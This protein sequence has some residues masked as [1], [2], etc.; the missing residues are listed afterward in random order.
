[1]SPASVSRWPS[2]VL[3]TP[4]LCAPAVPP[5]RRTETLRPVSTNGSIVDFG[6]NLVG[7]LRVRRRPRGDARDPAPRRDPRQRRPAVHRAVA[8]GAR[9]PTRSRG[10]DY[11]PRFTFHGF[12]YAEITGVDLDEVDVEAVVVHTDLERIGTFECSDPLLN[13]LH[14]NVVWGWRGNS[15]SVPT[16]CPQRDERLGWTGD[17]QVFS[18]TASFLYDAETFWE[19]W[20]ARRRRR[21]AR[22][23]RGGERRARH[24][25]RHPRRVRVGRRRRR[26]AVDDVRRLRRRH[27]AARRAA[28]DARVGRL[29]V[30]APRRRPSLDAGL[31]V[32]RLARPGR[33]D[34]TAVARQGEVRPRRHRLRRARRR[35]VGARRDRGRRRRAGRVVTRTVRH[36]ARRVVEALRRRRC[37]RH[38][39][40]RRSRSPSTSCPTTKRASRWARR[41]R[42]ACTTPAT[43]SPPGSSARRCCCPRSRRP[44][45][46]TSPTTCCCN[47]ARPS[48][49][50]T[51]LA[52]ATTI[53]ERWD[54]LRED[55]SV[56]LGSLDIGSGSSM[57][58]YNHYA[59]G[60][61]PMD[62]RGDR[63]PASRPRRPRLPPLLRR[64]APRWRAH[65]RV[66]VTADAL[67]PRVRR[68][69][70]RRRRTPRRRRSPTQHLGHR[71]PPRPRPRHRRQRHAL[72]VSEPRPV[73]G[74][75][76]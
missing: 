6:Q 28:V 33:A 56:P 54:A 70:P 8:H 40:A 26:R 21:S 11:E 55:G 9:R 22:R 42:C 35:S 17:A 1:M 74:D 37:A 59:Y 73:G 60:A 12:R 18:P 38:K 4:P 63:R 61:V 52:G 44:A 34:R 48:W 39:P 49:L 7:W 32:R 69:A 31:P 19:N 58:S 3:D 30:L 36:R 13:R 76:N 57:V 29:R 75:S 51:V 50:Y 64:A 62:A 66:G 67:R 25:P 72:V 43:T 23:R 68:L 14:E 53:W 41:S 65:A 10:G 27:G 71:H 5:V 46:S 47:A 24:R 16:D 15:V 45:T 2:A 20:L